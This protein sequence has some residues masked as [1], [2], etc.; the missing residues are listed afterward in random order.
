[1]KLSK[2]YSNNDKKF[3]PIVFNEGLNILYATVKRPKAS[4]KDSHNLGK[5]LL[6]KL[7]DFMLLA[8]LGNGHFLYDHKEFF[9]DFEFYLELERNAGGYATIRRNVTKNT[10]IAMKVHSERNL[11]FS[12]APDIVW[13]IDKAPLRQAR[14]E[15]NAF[16]GLT[17]IPT[18]SYRKGLTYFLRTQADYS[19]VFQTSK[20]VMGKHVYWK[21]FV[22]NVLGFPF[23]LVEEK[24]K[25]DDAIT[26]KEQ[27]R[28]E[29]SKQVGAD[30]TE[31]D[32][33]KGTI[34]IKREEV[35]ESRKKIDSFNFF[36]KE[37]SINAELVN[38]I[39][40]R[41]AYL[42][43]QLYE[44]GL[45]I[46]RIRDS[47]ASKVSF[48][49][50]QVKQIFEDAKIFFPTQLTKSYEDLQAFNAK[51]S[52]DRNKRLE[53]RLTVLTGGKAACET[54][55]SKFNR[56]REGIL[57]VLQS[58]D[59]FTKFRLFQTEIIQQETK[60]AQ[61]EA[62]LTNLDAMSR[63]DREIREQVQHR[64]EL[65]LRI[66]AAVNAGNSTY[67][68]IRH[69]FNE[70]IR[71]VLGHPALL[72]TKVNAEGNL[73]FNAQ[74]ISDEQ[75]LTATS[76]GKGTSYKKML[77]AAFDMA[78]LETYADKSFYRFVYH[79]G[80]LEGFDNRVKSRFLEAVGKYC[81][82]Y[83]LQYILTVIDADLPRGIDDARIP[84]PRET[85]VRELHD[86]GDSGRLFNMPK[87]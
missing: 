36:E 71:E 25:I 82:D 24:Y 48:D 69:K 84:F 47:L 63:I 50:A 42:N 68:S 46:E 19:D 9:E 78:V 79:D 64:Q 7:I 87:F 86:A 77:C 3:K 18:C 75:T 28:K 72:S 54:E 62:E 16:L 22:A 1:M 31:Y 21:P 30:P 8:E 81:N 70:I 59:T 85:I 2:I 32:R 15:L 67:T 57:E 53:R 74:L 11:D 43:E 12:S 35:N 44:I 61:L 56:E 49:L 20:F 6:I 34:E 60:I 14:E 45:E 39:E 51:L 40:R 13:D 29:Y 80:I 27:F 41:I 58:K 26:Q 65:A 52:E 66:E 17:A 83:K 55:L 37:L 76:E 23:E 5:T 33:I 38:Q 10:K 4:D 73:E